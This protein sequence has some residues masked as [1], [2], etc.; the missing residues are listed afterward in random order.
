M[1]RMVGNLAAVAVAV[2]VVAAEGILRAVVTLPLQR[3]EP[4]VSYLPH[5][6]RRFT[7]RP[8]QSA[9]TYGAPTVADDRG[10]RVNGPAVGRVE[11]GP[12]V[13]ALGD[14][15]TFGLGVRDEETWPTRVEARL[16]E[17]TGNPVTVINGGTI[18]YGVF[19]ELDLL[20]T[21]GLKTRPPLS[22]PRSTGTTS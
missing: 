15:F 9:Y 11:A 7:L 17:T 2:S 16:R 3:T 20:R 18:N 1:R 5:T 22:S 8:T 13:F 21:A 6:V 4:E 14:S 12:T 10:F 19:Q